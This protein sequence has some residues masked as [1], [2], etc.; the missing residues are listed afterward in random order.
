[1]SADALLDSLLLAYGPARAV[2]HSAAGVTERRGAGGSLVAAVEAHGL[3]AL[4]AALPVGDR[5][6]LDDP[7]VELELSRDA[8]GA[9]LR[10]RWEGGAAFEEQVT[11]PAAP[12]P[13][14]G[15]RAPPPL[16]APAPA[17]PAPAP[18]VD[19]APAADAA[20]ALRGPA[21]RAAL[22]HPTTPLRVRPDGSIAAGPGPGLPLPAA[23]PARLG[24]GAFTAAH[25][26]RLPVLSGAMAGGIGSVDILVEMAAAGMMGS[27]GAGGLPLTEIG[28]ALADAAARLPPGA[29]ACWNLLHS[30]AEPGLEDATVDLYLSHGVTRVEA[31]AFMALTPALVRFRLRG[32]RVV[33]GR[34]EARHRIIAKVSRPETAEAF[35]RPAPAA[36]LAELVAAGAL[37][38]AEA[39]AGA[40][41]PVADDI[42]VEADSGGHTDRRP[43]VVVLPA[44]LRLRDR[45]AAA[46]G[47]AARGCVPRVGAAGGLGDPASV[48]AAFALGAAYVVT[49]SVNQACAES[50][51]SPL[52]RDMLAAAKV[53]DCVSGP[54]P[55]MFEIGAQVQV[56]GAG[57]LYAQRAGRLYELYRRVAGL[58]D[59]PAD[60]RAKI[61]KTI[62]QRPL[63][64][65][66]ADTRAFWA[67]R[68]PRE[69]ARA[70]ADP[71][72]QMALTFR[73]YLG[74]SSR[75]ARAGDASRQRDF[76]IWCGP[77][78]GLF[79]DWTRGTPWAAPAA[80]R[81]AAVNR[82]LV[83]GAA[84]LQRVD[85]AAA[86]GAT[87]PDGA[88][89]VPPEAAFAGA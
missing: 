47:Y 78:M 31:S 73:W 77:A 2:L 26:L 8:A 41:L 18:A 24:G 28:R 6:L 25:G 86:L 17:P 81:V 22:H 80:R 50:G 15:L 70:E 30:P 75:W 84:L 85:A 27:F 79:N 55:D 67:Q 62:F 13:L 61:E 57:T 45:I 54:A 76:Q 53:T 82:A 39:A 9:R 59:I 40:L 43:L 12:R 19:A 63:D 11:L 34:A 33:D 5:L 48:Y 16:P 29:P 44:L 88:R 23:D 89:D 64:D 4:A 20:P 65:V 42:T 7:G 58:H 1:M 38:P 32:A 21:L 3:G 37:S 10:V 56:L 83:T 14:A 68:D 36:L 72:H 71:R 87:L 49:G 51:T 69:L 74:L 66:W 52:V 46:E 60:E 35:L